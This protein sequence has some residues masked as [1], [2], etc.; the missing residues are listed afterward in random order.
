MS[1]KQ[2]LVLFPKLTQWTENSSWKGWSNTSELQ[3]QESTFK[4]NLLLKKKKSLPENVLY[5]RENVPLFLWTECL[6]W[7]LCNNGGETEVSWVTAVL[8]TLHSVNSEPVDFGLLVVLQ[9]LLSLPSFKLQSTCFIS[10]I[11]HSH[12]C[13]FSC[14]IFYSSCLV[15]RSCHYITKVLHHTRGW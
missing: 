3:P 6:T 1:T 9:L 7:L 10:L 13:A 5:L 2:C 15:S 8:Q 11:Q 12:I 4:V 14:F